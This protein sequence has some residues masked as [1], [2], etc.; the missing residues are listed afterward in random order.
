MSQYLRN[1]QDRRAS[2]GLGV[3]SKL[4][5]VAGGAGNFG[6]RIVEALLRHPEIRVRVPARRPAGIKDPRVERVSLDIASASD[7]EREAAVGGA[8]SIVSALQGGPELIVD[9]Q[10]AL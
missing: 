8:F 10:L 4:I 6:H 3:M 2:L 9:A 1:C 5:V 7:A